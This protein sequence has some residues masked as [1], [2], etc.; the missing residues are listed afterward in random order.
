MNNKTN[1]LNIDN[2]EVISSKANIENNKNKS[3]PTIIQRR[4]AII[5]K[6]LNLCVLVNYK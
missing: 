3:K 6:K 5:S 4:L 2:K 1:T